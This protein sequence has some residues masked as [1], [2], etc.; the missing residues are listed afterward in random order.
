MSS[1]SNPSK[2]HITH[3][4]R[5]IPTSWKSSL[6]PPPPPP[7][8]TTTNKDSPTTTIDGYSLLD[9]I[10]SLSKQGHLS[11]AFQTFSLLQT[12]RPNLTFHPL[13]PLLH[14]C[15]SLKSLPQGQQLHAHIISRGL[16]L[17]PNLGSMLVSFYTHCGLPKEAHVLTLT[18]LDSIDVLPWN[19]LIS[20]YVKCG[21]HRE[22]RLVYVEMLEIGIKADEFT[23]PTVLKA[24]GEESDVGF[25]GAVHKRIEETGLTMNSIVSNALVSAYVKCGEIAFARRVFESMVERDVV[26]WNAIMSGYASSGAWSEA[27]DLFERM[28]WEGWEP[29]LSTWNTVIGGHARGG[30][31]VRALELVSRMRRAVEGID[32]VAL[33]VS[34]DACSRFGFSGPG[35]EVHA[36]AVR[37]GYDARENVRNALIT[38]YARCGDLRSARALFYTAERR[39]MITWNCMI[40]G[41]AASDASED[42]CLVLREM[43][44]SM[45]KPNHVTLVSLLALFGR[46]RDLRRGREVHCYVARRCEFR[47][48]SVLWNS[49]IDLYAKAGRILNAHRVFDSIDVPDE[50]SYTSLIGGYGMQGDGASA[51]KLFEEMEEHGLRPDHVTMVSVLSACRRSGLIKQGAW[52]LRR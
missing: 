5:F 18:F 49:L 47:G 43:V 1:L 22:A 4:Q 34:L 16:S 33:L 40:S 35:R 21:F 19:T 46:A 29:S 38:M 39:S 25:V 13:S 8:T 26:S 23:Y 9:S 41:C 44:A 52:C 11:K 14:C 51:L 50:V 10:R 6:L 28:R 45:V 37:S 31:A 36:A 24:G 42:A 20:S 12:H 15:T 2:K 32:D 27:L 3:I 7:T 48:H 17:N 30:D